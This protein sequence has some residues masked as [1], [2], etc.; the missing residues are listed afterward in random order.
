MVPVVSMNFIVNELAFYEE[1]ASFCHV[2]F[3]RAKRF[4]P[5]EKEA[6]R[7]EENASEGKKA[8]MLKQA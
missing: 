7:T 8:C 6:M 2:K 4:Q 3:G 1:I 5:L